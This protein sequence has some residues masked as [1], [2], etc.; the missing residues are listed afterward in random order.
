MTMTAGVKWER[1]KEEDE[2]EEAREPYTEPL[3]GRQHSRRY[4]SSYC[5]PLQTRSC[6]GSIEVARGMTV[7]CSSAGNVG[8][9]QQS[10][11]VHTAII[12]KR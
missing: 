8:R 9:H 2:K 11:N 6:N 12:E 1:E 3:K 7:R 5:T 4:Q 10:G